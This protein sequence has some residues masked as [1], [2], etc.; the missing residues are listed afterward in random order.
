MESGSV[1]LG[2]YHLHEQVGTG[3]SGMVWRATDQLLHQLVALKRVSFAGLDD[4]QA[5]LTRNRAL[6]EARLAAQLNAHPRVITVYDVRVEDGDIWLVME[7]LPSRTLRELL[8]THGRLDPTAA[9]RIGAQVA[10]ALAAAHARGIEHRDV[11]PGNVLIGHDG[12]VKLADFGISH[13]T[14][15]PHLTHTGITGTPAYLAPEVV[16]RGESSSASDVFSLGST[17]YAAVEG[18]PP[19]GIDDNTFRLLNIV[20]N[21][22]IRPPT[23]A[24]PLEPLLLRLLQLDPTTRPD[25]ATTRDLLTQLTTQLTE[26]TEHL[27][28]RSSPPAQPRAR[29]WPPARRTPLAAGALLTL[30]ATAGAIGLSTLIGNADQG[31]TPSTEVPSPTSTAASTTGPPSVPIDPSIQT[32]RNADPCPLVDLASLNQFGQAERTT[33]RYLQSCNVTFT[34]PGR[35]HDTG[36]WVYFKN[37]EPVS[38]IEG[39]KEPVGEL[40][41][42]RG[43]LDPFPPR[44]ECENYLWLAE[45]QPLIVIH[46]RTSDPEPDALCAV[47]ET[48]TAAAVTALKRDGG[49]TYTDNRT[50]NYSHAGIDACATLDSTALGKAPSLDPNDPEPGFANWSCTWS[51]ND[52]TEVLLEFM[53][54]EPGFT[55][56]RG[57]DRRILAGKNALLS[58][59]S[60]GCT[61]DVVHRPDPAATRATEM[62]RITVESSLP[63]EAVCDLAAELAIAVEERLP[64]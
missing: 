22:I 57:E 55:G 26:T 53:L 32:L 34:A 39:E 59:G 64:G 25:A 6:R 18:Q 52:D 62:F 12:V 51:G 9:A 15:D 19:F 35:S 63:T 54:E 36:V 42:V 24:G 43:D 28:P 37:S 61:A 2:R 7:Y 21:G 29:W 10:D 20:R 38:D 41:I 8:H 47:T 31:G 33:E 48:A 27:H 13:L 60:D 50:A 45:D 46:V 58:G 11:K 1:V 3:G 5:R 16:A 56:Y 30:A 4:E 23:H 40:I 14:G 17:L 49:I 44:T